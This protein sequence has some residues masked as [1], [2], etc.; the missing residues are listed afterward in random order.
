VS[1]RIVFCWSGGKDS[2]LALHR[3]LHDDRYTVVSL[4]TTVNERFERVSMHGVRLE[5]AQAQARAIGLPLD[6]VFVDGSS[7]DEYER[8]MSAH[9]LAHKEHG[10]SNVAFGDIFL[11]DL[12]RWR[13][14]NLA[15][16]GMR[17]LFPLWRHDTREV[18]GEFI[19]L[20]FR[21]IVCCVSDAYLDEAALGRIVDWDFINSLPSDV[22]PCG[23]NGEFH[24]FAYA[25][26]IFN[27][28]I[29]VT[30]GQKVYR[31]VEQTTRDDAATPSAPCPSSNTRSAKGFWF[32]DLMRVRESGA[33]QDDG[34]TVP[35]VE[36]Q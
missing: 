33:V 31:L 36:W 9:L 10:V 2:A 25:G 22:D 1:E 16:I 11:E 18:I 27:D 8:N 14:G 7:N 20:G 35:K 24:S 34:G 29:H 12:R 19:D 4:L 32:C 3:L 28:R 23:E 15:R 30:V 13:E 26:P 21:A 17:G 5:L 6:I